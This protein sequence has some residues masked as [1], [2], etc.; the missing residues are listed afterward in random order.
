LSRLTTALHPI[1]ARNP[2]SRIVLIGYPN[3][4]P[5]SQSSAV[6]CGW[7]S[8]SER[9]DLVQLATDLDATSRDAARAAG[10]QFA[11]LLNV[12]AAHQSCNANSWMYPIAAPGGAIQ[13][14]GH[15]N[16]QGQ[17]A[18]AQAVQLSLAN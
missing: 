10:V 7:L 16:A 2:N 9:A 18:M 14:N 8:R 5:A 12:L 6:N 1:K 4:F 15:P 3:L 11:S 17:V 13:F